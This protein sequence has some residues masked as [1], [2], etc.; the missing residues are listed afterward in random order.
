MLDH[1]ERTLNYVNNVAH[2][3]NPEIFIFQENSS[4]SWRMKSQDSAIQ[5]N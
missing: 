1:I 3:N 4:V 2:L 5:G